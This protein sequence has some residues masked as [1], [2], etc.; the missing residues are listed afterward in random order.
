MAPLWPFL[1]GT[2]AAALALRNRCLTLLSGAL[3]LN[4]CINTGYVRYT[5][6]E[7]NFV[8]FYIV[9]MV[10]AVGVL[11]S[12]P[13]SSRSAAIGV[14]YLVELI[15]HVAYGFATKGIV[16]NWFYWWALYDIA[17]LQIALVGSFILY[18]GARMAFRRR[19]AHR[20][21]MACRPLP[22]GFLG[23]EAGGR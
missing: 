17:A 1:I 23:G 12:C 11:L 5:G 16:A 14:T 10:T 15:A 3:L 7:L 21:S 8:V 4:W 2:F 13:G 9:D 22:T 6:D 20:G 18:G 19:H